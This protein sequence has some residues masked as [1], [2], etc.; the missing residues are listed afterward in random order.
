MQKLQEAWEGFQGQGFSCQDLCFDG[1]TNTTPSLSYAEYR[2]MSLLDKWI[3]L[4]QNE[5]V[6]FSTLSD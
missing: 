2:S 3:I 5:A 1:K 4:D 6:L